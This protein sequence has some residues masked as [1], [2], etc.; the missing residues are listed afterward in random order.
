MLREYDLLGPLEGMSGLV[1]G[2]DKGVDLI[3]NLASRGETR[4]GQS[5]GGEN[6]KPDL[7]LIEARRHG[8]A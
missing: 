4:A 7:D 8:S 2:V 6:G 1:I 5:F 3:A